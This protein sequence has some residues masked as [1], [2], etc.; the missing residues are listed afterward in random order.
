MMF[1]AWFFAYDISYVILLILLVSEN[2][3]VQ[4][5][6]RDNDS[7]AQENGKVRRTIST[8]K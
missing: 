5:F 6:E 4:N 3:G 8:L 1:L 2:A 7:E